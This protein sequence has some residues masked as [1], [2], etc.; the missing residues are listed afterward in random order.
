LYSY[1]NLFLLSQPCLTHEGAIKLIE[2]INEEPSFPE[3]KV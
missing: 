2:I 3:G 1:P